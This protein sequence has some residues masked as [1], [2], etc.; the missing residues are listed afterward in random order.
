M[1]DPENV[2]PGVT[3]S[4]PVPSPTPAAPGPAP[5]GPAPYVPESSGDALFDV[6][7]SSFSQNYRVSQELYNSAIAPAIAAGDVSK[8]DHV[9]LVAKLGAEGAQA[10]VRI[11]Q[12]AV[13]RNGANETKATLLVHSTAGSA[14]NWAKAVAAFNTSQPDFVKQQMNTLLN[15]GDEKQIGYAASQILRAAQVAGV[16]TGAL[17]VGLGGSAAGSTGLSAA[18]FKEAQAALRKEA[19]NRSLESG[20]F[21][22]KW[23]ALQAQRTLGRSQGL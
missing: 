3:P 7:V 22:V 18:Q 21:A 9:Q 8:L 10:A 4:A 15:S 11:A 6:A 16:L 12:A 14:E 2:V 23:Q 1:A 20:P 5:A 13:A 19:G 17:P